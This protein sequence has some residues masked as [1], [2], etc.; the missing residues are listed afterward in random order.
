MCNQTIKAMAKKQEAT[1]SI[2]LH[3]P[4]SIYWDMKTKRDE[5][6]RKG[7]KVLLQDEFVKLIIESY[8]KNK[9]GTVR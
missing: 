3:I 7:E 5:R 8:G 6:S 4:E 2:V 1:K 9:K